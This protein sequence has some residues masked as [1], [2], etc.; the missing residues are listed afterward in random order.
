MIRAGAFVLLLGFLA[1][2]QE[3]AV[4][5]VA[6]QK[7]R[8]LSPEDRARLKQRLDEVRKLPPAEKQRLEENLKK[9][10]ALG[11]DEVRKLREKATQLSSE[12]KKEYHELASG[13]F[14]WTK[15]RQ[16]DPHFPRG[17]FFTWLKRERPEELQT[18][19]SLDPGNRVDAFVKLYIQFRN[20]ILS[21]AE[22]HAARHRCAPVHEIRELRDSA[23]DELW[24]KFQ[25]FQRSCQGHNARPGPVA[26]RP[27][28]PA[29][30]EKK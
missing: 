3:R 4:D 1:G 22:Q 15:R 2:A 19:R 16:I 29:K 8:S 10:K 17:L 13:F 14:R 26:P 21:R 12:E 20:D 5:P 6:L 7:I 9:L 18:I 11:A 27:L 28:E 25:E 30:G 24:P 23:P